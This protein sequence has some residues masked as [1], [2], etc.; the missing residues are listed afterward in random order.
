M[1]R[2]LV[3]LKKEFIRPGLHL[4]S[5]CAGRAQPP[6]QWAL[7]SVLSAYGNENGR[8]RPSLGRGIQAL[9]EQRCF[10]QH[11]MGIYTVLQGGYSQQ[12]Q[13]LKFQ[14]YKT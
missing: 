5:V 11:G 1:D 7:N 12:R 10:N 13:I 14:T 3:V 4:R 9:M 8:I 6:L 2:N